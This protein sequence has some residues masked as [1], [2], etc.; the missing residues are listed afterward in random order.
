MKTCDSATCF[1]PSSSRCSIPPCH[2]EHCC[3]NYKKVYKFTSASIEVFQK[4]QTPL[5]EVTKY[6]W[7]YS[8][9]FISTDQSKPLTFFK[10][11][12]ANPYKKTGLSWNK[13][14]KG[15]IIKYINKK[16]NWVV[17]LCVI[18]KCYM[19]SGLKLRFGVRFCFTDSV[20]LYV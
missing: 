9:T 8:P 6:Q 11:N 12:S 20:E 3:N 17:W 18:E 5:T 2:H 13:K 4:L 19:L 1:S 14:R 10:W 16:R 7:K 15:N